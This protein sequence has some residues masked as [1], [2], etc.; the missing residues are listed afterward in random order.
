MTRLGTAI[1]F[2]VGASA[3]IFLLDLARLTGAHPGWAG[4]LFL[5]GTFLGS[6]LAFLVVHLQFVPR[7]IGLSLLVIGAYLTADYGR[8]LFTAP[9]AEDRIAGQMWFYGWHVL[10]ITLVAHIISVSYERLEW[11]QRS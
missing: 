11:A 2:G 9:F 5:S 1:C 7:T 3:L 8:M 4:H 6:L 10:C